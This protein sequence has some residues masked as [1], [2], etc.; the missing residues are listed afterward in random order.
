MSNWR[1]IRNTRSGDSSEV[2]LARVK[3]CGSFWCRFRGL[4]LRTSL[5]EDEGLLF[6][7]KRSSVAET[8]IHMFFVFFP[9]AAVWLDDDGRVVDA[10]L[11]RPWRPFYKPAAAAR[12]LIEA[13]PALLDRVQVGDLLTF[14]ESA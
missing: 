14:G 7:F 10:K 1:V 6:D 11:A 9:I 2:A 12:Y 4:M 3:W 5:P 13:R 8:T